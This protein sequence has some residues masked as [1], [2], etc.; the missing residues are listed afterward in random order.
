MKALFKKK[1]LWCFT[2]RQQHCQDTAQKHADRKILKR[3]FLANL[4]LDCERVRAHKQHNGHQ[5]G[6]YDPMLKELGLRYE[7][8]GYSGSQVLVF[9]PLELR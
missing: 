6:L 5:K 2:E 1:G 4:Y 9:S 8:I 3:F 7:S